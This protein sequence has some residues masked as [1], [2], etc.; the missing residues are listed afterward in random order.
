MVEQVRR[1]FND[2]M[3]PQKAQQLDASDNPKEIAHVVAT[4]R[5]YEITNDG[6]ETVDGRQTYHLLL[7]P[8]HHSSKLRLREMWI[9]T[10]TFATRRLLTQVNFI[11]GKV[12]WLVTFTDVGGAQYIS[13]EVAQRPVGSGRH[14]YQQAEITFTNI[15]PAQPPRYRLNA[16][17]PSADVLTEPP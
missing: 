17:L 16:P 10:Q 6:I 15:V 11:D 4:N 14:L 2:P 8:E 3:P 12:P 5:D 1:A 13:S 9:D 7:R